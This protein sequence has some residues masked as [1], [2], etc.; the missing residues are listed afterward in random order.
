[1]EQSPQITVLQASAGSGK[2]YNLAYRFIRRILQNPQLFHGILAV[3][4]TN[5]ATCQMKDRI[6]ESLQK[7]KQSPEDSDY[8]EKLLK[9][10]EISDSSA[11]ST[12]A[13]KAQM[14]ILS[15]YDRFAVST[16]D[17][18][19]SKVVR[20]FFNELG[21]DPSYEVVIST[22]ELIDK[23]IIDVISDSKNSEL[24]TPL[25]LQRTEERGKGYNIK[26]DIATVKDAIL[27]L[28]DNKFE[29]GSLREIVKHDK[30]TVT[31]KLA[32]ISSKASVI[33]EYLLP[34]EGPTEEDYYQK[35]RGLV[36]CLRKIAGEETDAENKIVPNRYF[37]EIVNGEKD[38]WQAKSPYRNYIESIC[39][40]LSSDLE[41]MCLLIDSYNSD[42]ASVKNTLDAVG[43]KVN[44]LETISAVYEKYLENCN[45][46]NVVAINEM[47]AIVGEIANNADL[48]FLYMKIG[49]LLATVMIDEF[50]DTSKEQWEGF[51]PIIEE[52]CSHIKDP[53][54]LIIG[55]LKQAIYRWRG[56]DE[57]LLRE[58]VG[59]DFIISGQPLDKNFRS[60]DNIIAFNNALYSQIAKN[61]ISGDEFSFCGKEEIVS[62]ANNIIQSTYCTAKQELGNPEKQEGGYVECLECAK[63]DIT[64]TVIKKIQEEILPSGYSLS[65]IAVITRD[66]LSATRM[67][68]A[69]AD[70]GIQF[71]SAESL[72]LTNSIFVRKMVALMHVAINSDDELNMFLYNL[73]E[74][75]LAESKINK[76]TQTQNFESADDTRKVELDKALC[77]AGIKKRIDKEKLDLLSAASSMSL[78]E[79]VTYIQSVMGI[80]PEPDETA[81]C[82]YFFDIVFSKYKESLSLSEFVSWWDDTGSSSKL[83]S[84]EGQNAVCI[85]TI[86]KSKGL[87]YPV[88]IAPY[89]DWGFMPRNNSMVLFQADEGSPYNKFGT[90]P[91]DYNEKRLYNSCFKE[92][93][94]Q[95]AQQSIM[96][97]LNLLYVTT[98][99]AK[100]R[101]YLITPEKPSSHSISLFLSKFVK[102]HPIWGEPADKKNTKER[103]QKEIVQIDDITARKFNGKLTQAT[104][105][106]TD[107]DD[108]RTTKK[109]LGILMHQALSKIDS[110]DNLE[111]ETRHLAEVKAVSEEQFLPLVNKILNRKEVREWFDKK[112]KTF[113]E[114]GIIIPGQKSGRRP[115]RVMVDGNS[116]IVVDYKFGRRILDDNKQVQEYMTLLQK[117]GYSDIKGYIYYVSLDRIV[118]I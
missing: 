100:E 17:K 10:L 48:N 77:A 52:I 51:K 23:A 78:C 97:N 38:P 82:D 90:I 109:Y 76:L 37:Y 60:L 30:E 84:P 54:N 27:K 116:A 101:L 92:A 74:C 88:V 49:I 81:F 32:E 2:T 104:I 99:R 72:L 63:E 118:Q 108:P 75:T 47:P 93:Y 31:A 57:K 20:S 95:E 103:Q 9:D 41:G 7:L 79:G 58:E 67:A 105:F 6:L 87:E 73:L 85:V 34:H 113:N 69:F 35:K 89:L 14:E 18:F 61:G 1:M 21:K 102:E 24:L 110:L 117:M 107:N 11:L 86:H 56:G 39:S 59:S 64:A 66:N 28:R 29:V 65:D 15:D 94:L 19:F 115:D 8:T 43:G 3:T 98:T 13:S 91:L 114:R 42:T 55:D 106:S 33:L 44:I 26:E 71:V 36:G 50:Q 46:D 68:D 96:D 12:R 16:I 83:S 25:F 22:S 111:K 5:K 112:W 45:K 80:N 4:F 70:E 53:E 40:K 62:K